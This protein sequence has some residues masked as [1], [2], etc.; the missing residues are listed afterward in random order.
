M[1]LYEWRCPSCKRVVEVEMKV[2]DPLKPLCFEG[3]CDGIEMERIISKSS[4][5]LAG[6]GWAKDGYSSK[7]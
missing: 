3:S 2:S 7:K 6:S 1:P 5:V 4:F